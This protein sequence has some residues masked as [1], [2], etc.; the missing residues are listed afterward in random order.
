MKDFTCLFCFFL[1]Y[2]TCLTDAR[3]QEPQNPFIKNLIREGFE[4]VGVMQDKGDTYIFYENRLYRWEIDGLSKILKE[5]ANS[6]NDSTVLHLVP[7]HRQVAVTVITTKMGEYKKVLTHQ[8]VNELSKQIISVAMNTDSLNSMLK[9]TKLQNKSF[10]KIDLIFL[11]GFKVQFGNY[12]N[13]VEWQLSISPILQTYL[14]K[15]MLIT[16]QILIPLH[17]ELQQSFEGK[18]RLETASV[19]QLFRLPKNVFLNVSG[20]IFPYQNKLSSYTDF[21]RY[22]FIS[23]LRKYFLN[24]KICTGGY[25]GLTGLMNISSGYLNYW[26]LQKF[27]F[28]VYGEYRE[29]KFDFTTRLTVGK[30]LYEDFALRL[31]LSR[32]FHEFNLGLFVIKSNLT[33]NSGETGTVGGFNVSIPIGLRKSFKPSPFRVNLAKYF[34]WEFRERTVD[35]VATTFKTDNE[36][37]ETV[38]NLNPDFTKKQL[39]AQ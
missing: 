15:G 22:G 3:S 2:F 4:N 37:N 18:V 11:P 21:K 14:W 26:P 31:D 17:N 10:R 19:N 34:N 16:A 7:L 33:S 39:L 23:D 30:F 29:P 24:S 28:A 38:R 20:G 32:Q 36:W 1:F 13:P 8:T 9:E 25:L 27:N 12:D 5:A 6:F 35:P